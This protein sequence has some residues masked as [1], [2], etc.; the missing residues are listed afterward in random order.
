M[1]SSLSCSLILPKGYRVDDILNFHRRDRHQIAE[2]VTASSL[3]KGLVWQGLPARLTLY[4]HSSSVLAELCV[5][6]RTSPTCQRHFVAMVQRMLGLFQDIHAFEEKYRQHQSLKHLLQRQ[7]GLRVPVA[8]S[9]FEALTWAVTGQQISIQ[10][11]VSIRRKLI[12]TAG[13]RHSSGLWCCPEAPQINEIKPQALRSAGFSQAKIRTLLV[14]SKL[15]CN[16][17]LPLTQW[18]ETLPVNTIASELL[19]VPGIG[20]WTVNYGLLRGFGWMDGSLHGDVA[21][22]RGIQ[23]LL[24]EPEKIDITTAKIWLAQ[25]SPWR[26]LVAAH[27]WAY[28]PS[29]ANSTPK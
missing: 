16:G 29:I 14:L 19:A 10:A 26:A 13:V 22:R 2:V 7:S 21:V 17:Q 11:A 3:Q 18:L 5:D 28:N 25:F 20:A 24:Q 12:Q 1:T 8:S 4:F 6:G 15:V 27:L 23:H 9:P